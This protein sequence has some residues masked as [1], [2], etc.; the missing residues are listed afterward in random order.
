MVAIKKDAREEE[1]EDDNISSLKNFVSSHLQKFFVDHIHV[2]SIKELPIK[3][4]ISIC[5]YDIT[6]QVLL[7]F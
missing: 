1:E 2:D 7:R 3:C 4:E 6:N 5:P